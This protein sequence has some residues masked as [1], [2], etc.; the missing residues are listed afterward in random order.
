MLPESGH[1]VV[2]WV[3]VFRDDLGLPDRLD[4]YVASMLFLVTLADLRLVV[5]I[6]IFILHRSRIQLRQKLA[7]G[8]FLCLSIVMVAISITRSAKIQGPPGVPEDVTWMLFWVYS[9]SAIA[10]LMVSL[11]AF[12]TVFNLKKE[13]ESRKERLKKPPTYRQYENYERKQEKDVEA[14][15]MQGLPEIPSATLQGVDAFIRWNGRLESDTKI[16]SLGR[17]EELSPSASVSD[18]EKKSVESF[19]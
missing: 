19:V 15:T 6:P 9:E 7:V 13:E 2:C 8:T 5:S 3:D 16:L 18:C 12:R 1:E 17:R 14:A 4:E 10:I 11:T